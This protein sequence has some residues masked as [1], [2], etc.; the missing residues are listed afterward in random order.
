MS[1]VHQDEG[2]GDLPCSLPLTGLLAPHSRF[3]TFVTPVFGKGRR[4]FQVVNDKYEVDRFRVVRPRVEA[5]GIEYA[6]PTNK[7]VEAVSGEGAVY[8]FAFSPG[9]VAVGSKAELSKVL[10]SRMSEL[11][12]NPFLSVSV[13]VFIGDQAAFDESV[14][15][16]AKSIKIETSEV[17]GIIRLPNTVC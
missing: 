14:N 8:A 9:D 13:A 6:V 11:A 15:R 3:P 4:Y 5:L 1:G 7:R 17:L 2:N 12:D 10:K 16:A